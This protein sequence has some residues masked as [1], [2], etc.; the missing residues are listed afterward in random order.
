MKIINLKTSLLLLA[1]ASP[2]ATL[3]QTT[4][5]SGDYT[6][7]A[8]EREF[9]LGGAGA[10]NTD[11][12]NSLGG[13]NL[14]LGTYINETLMWSIRQSVNYSNP[15]VGGTQWNGAT[16]L[17]IDQHFASRGAVRPF[18][19]ANFGRVY[20]DAVNDTWAAGLE[21]GVKFYVQPRTFVY[22]LAEYGWFFE[23]TRNVRNRFN[24]G[25]INWGVGIGFN[26]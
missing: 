1:L 16:R 12:D 3:A 6:R 18:V 19:G 20:G 23:R 8:G 26:F 10:T 24:D 9:T 11:F 22:A 4:V 5:A 14:S 17:A 21:A 2:L 7:R 15:N 25:Q 13:V